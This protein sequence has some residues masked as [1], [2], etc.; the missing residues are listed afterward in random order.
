MEKIAF[1]DTKPYDRPG[2]D[3]LLPDYPE[4]KL[5]YLETDL[6]PGTARLAEGYDA[7]C[8]FVNADLGAATLCELARAQKGRASIMELNLNAL[9][10]YG[11]PTKG[12]PMVTDRLLNIQFTEV[13]K[14]MSQ[15]DKNMEVSLP[16]VCTDIHYNIP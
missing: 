1:F 7:I 14:S 6:S 2:F 13:E 4:L 9:V 11:D 3:A 5:D 10:C 15:G 12:D 16:F 8:A